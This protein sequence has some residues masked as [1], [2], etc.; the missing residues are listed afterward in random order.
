MGLFFFLL[1]TIVSATIFVPQ[2]LSIQLKD[3][4]SVI[5]GKF[6]EK[7]S[8]RLPNG[9]IVTDSTF[10]VTKGLEGE[11]ASGL[12]QVMTPGGQIGDLVQVIDGTPLFKKDEEVILLLKKSPEGFWVHNLSLGKYLLKEIKGHRF[13]QSE[14]FSNDPQLAKIPYEKFE[15]M[16]ADN[17]KRK[18]VPVESIISPQQVS[19]ISAQNPSETTS[20]VQK[21]DNDSSG[22]NLKLISTIFGVLLFILGLYRW[23]KSSKL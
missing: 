3:S 5:Q 23:K 16:V 13:L 12:I 6:L 18:L 22:L 14:I 2:P 9:S 17:F 15:Q 19:E 1:S 11:N 8:R 21:L 4:S 10:Q 20:P 7:S